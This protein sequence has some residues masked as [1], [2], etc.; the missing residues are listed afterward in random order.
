MR[1]IGIDWERAR[2]EMSQRK[3]ESVR[4]L[5][6]VRMTTQRCL[7]SPL[8]VAALSILVSAGAATAGESPCGNDFCA[9]VDASQLDGYRAQGIDGPSAGD[10]K[11]GVILWDEYRRQRQPG[12]TTGVVGDGAAIMNASISGGTTTSVH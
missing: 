9:P 5:G 10:T 6:V 1:F 3:K 12:D 7:L 4:S 2:R 8:A 11:L